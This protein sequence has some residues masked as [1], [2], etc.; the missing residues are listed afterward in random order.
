MNTANILVICTNDNYSIHDARSS[1]PLMHAA[2]FRH[3][4]VVRVLLEDGVNAKRANIFQWTALH[5]AA[6]YGHLDV[7]R[8]LPDWGVNLGPLN[9]W[10]DSPLHLAA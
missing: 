10:E 3:V 8:L 4:V 5:Y 1:T 9:T 6:C 2:I 7:C